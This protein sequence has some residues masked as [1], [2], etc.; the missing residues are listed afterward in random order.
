MAWQLVEP[1]NG[2]YREFQIRRSDLHNF[3][4]VS[5][6]ND[7]LLPSLC[8]WQAGAKTVV[9]KLREELVSPSWRAGA[10]SCEIGSGRRQPHLDVKA[11]ACVAAVCRL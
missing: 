1:Q 2:R 5:R 6:V 10:G 9:A 11:S 7:V 8:A 4:W 3:S